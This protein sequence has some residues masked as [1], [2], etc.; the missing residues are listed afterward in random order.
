MIDVCAVCFFNFVVVPHYLYLELALLP[1]CV[2]VS[3]R[4]FFDQSS[5]PLQLR[6][7]VGCCDGDC[8][9]LRVL[10]ETVLAQLAAEARLAVATCDAR[11]STPGSCVVN[12]R[13]SIE[14]IG[15]SLNLLTEWHGRLQHVVAVD[16]HGARADAV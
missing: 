2:G 3:T 7:F 16:P 15:A 5:L 4:H 14:N 6:V 10:G 8:L 12:K 9:N 1:S 13:T 11:A